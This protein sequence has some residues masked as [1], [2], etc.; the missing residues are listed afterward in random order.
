MS[1]EDEEK[2][3]LK[4]IERRGKSKTLKLDLKELGLENFVREPGKL[5]FLPSSPPLSFYDINTVGK[6]NDYA[7]KKKKKKKKKEKNGSLLCNKE[8]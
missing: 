6:K 2:K 3:K 5:L 4:K 1:G 7:K 8:K